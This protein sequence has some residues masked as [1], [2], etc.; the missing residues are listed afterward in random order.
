MLP[1]VIVHNL[2]SVD[3][4]IDFWEGNLGLYYQIAAQFDADAILSGSNTILRGLEMFDPEDYLGEGPGDQEPPHQRMVIVDSRGRI[5]QMHLLRKTPYWYVMTVLCSSTTPSSYLTHLADHDI[6]TI[7]TGEVQVDLRAALERLSADYGIRRIRVDSGGLL[8]GALLH[9]GLV[10][11]ISLLLAPCLI[12]RPSE[13][14][15]VMIPGADGKVAELKLLEMR[16]MPDDNVWLHYE[17][18]R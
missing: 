14:S 17:V 12:G 11:E 6:D 10:S 1:R 18:V 9:A 3:G 4:R 5:R 8:N 2:V 7:V 16:R 15:L 13:T